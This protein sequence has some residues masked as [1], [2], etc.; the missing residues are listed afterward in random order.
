M[1]L[2]VLHNLHRANSHYSYEDI[3]RLVATF[4]PDQ[5]GVEIRQE[6]LTFDNRYLTNNYPT[7][8]VHLAHQYSSHTFGFDWLGNE[9]AGRPIPDDWWAKH[10][11]IKSLERSFDQVLSK[12]VRDK[13]LL[14]KVNELSTEQMK[15]AKTATAAQLAD[16]RYDRVCAD[17]YTA[18]DKL[19][20]NTQYSELPRF[21][22]D[23]DRHLA[24]N[25]I[26]HLK[27]Y[28]GNRIVVVTGADHH[29]PMVRTLAA[30]SYVNLVPVP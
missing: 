2:P 20:R 18:L 23:R 6:D 7:E 25:V 24:M 10:S 12:T 19:T 29:G 15:I 26:Q 14:S 27:N 13:K 30:V 28:P 16:G 5:V 1:V 22:S 21:Y 11:R 3:Y 9:I 17:Y 8:M 4:R